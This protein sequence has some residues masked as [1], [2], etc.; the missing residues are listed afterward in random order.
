MAATRNEIDIV[1]DGTV[2][3]DPIADQSFI[4][5]LFKNRGLWESRDGMGTLL[6]FNGD[7]NA[8]YNSGASVDTGTFGLEEHLGSFYFN[9]KT[10]QIIS[11][12][13]GSGWDGLT[14]SGNTDNVKHYYIHIYD[15]TT[16]NR[17]T[18]ILYTHTSQENV[19]DQLTGFYQGYYESRGNVINFKDVVLATKTRFFFAEYLG[20][21][22]FGSKDAGV[23]VYNPALFIKTRTKLINNINNRN[24]LADSLTNHYSEGSMITPLAFKD[25][26]VDAYTYVQTSDINNIVD[27]DANDG[28]L[29]FAAGKSLYFSDVGVPNA[30]VGNNVF[31]FHELQTNITAIKSFNEL[32][33]VWSA[34]QMFVYQPSQG[35]LLSGGRAV[36]VNNEVGCLGP[37]AVLFRQNR[38]WWVD[39]NG[40]YSTGTG[41]STEEIS[42]PIKLFFTD[43]T[44]NPFIHY[45]TNAGFIGTNDNRPEFVLSA[46]NNLDDVHLAFDQKYEQLFVVFPK[47]NL[48]WVYKE[49]G[50]YI[51]SFSSIAEANSTVSAISSVDYP[52]IVCSNEK[53]FAVGGKLTNDVYYTPNSDG[54]G[55]SL[56]GKQFSWRLFELGRGGALDGSTNDFN[57]GKRGTGYYNTTTEGTG[58]DYTIYYDPIQ[59]WGNKLSADATQSTVYGEEDDLCVLPIWITPAGDTF[60]KITS[61]TIEF[62][63]DSTRFE[64][65]DW[66]GSPS[67]RDLVFVLPTER[68]IQYLGFS[69]GNAA[70]GPPPSGVSKPLTGTVRIQFNAALAASSWGWMNLNPLNKNAVIWIPFKKIRRDSGDLDTT[71]IITDLGANFTYTDG[72]G[73]SGNSTNITHRK[74]NPGWTHLRDDVEIANGVDWVYKS[75]QLGMEG[76]TQ[77]KARG[78]YSLVASRGVGDKIKNWSIGVWNSIAGSDYKDYVTQTLDVTDTPKNREALVTIFNKNDIRTRFKPLTD[79]LYRL[80][81]GSATYGSNVDPNEPGN[82]LVDT[83]EADTIATSDSVR[84]ESVNYTFFGF[85]LNKANKVRI[86]SIKIPFIPVAGRRRRGR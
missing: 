64:P 55:E 70:A 15:I 43:S 7:L 8:R 52:F 59:S 76:Q 19:E 61:F 6:E 62:Q 47:L 16:N 80:F 81:G 30:I 36:E 17:W 1:V 13:Y 74:W 31:T 83:E 18:E 60:N 5:N 56:I 82:Y 25:G 32:I 45:F 14:P 50:W 71:N 21:L 20:K 51:W 27:I 44:T 84:G 57:E 12:F 29:I 73:G 37:N 41:F 33:L 72:L 48:A 40:V 3:K 66:V 65:I 42:A 68:A 9:T 85:L 10:E 77:I 38:V 49:G 24:E 58:A 2:L 75:S 86:K 69:P 63:Y 79:L 11:V 78:S 67:L 34:D 35:F 23:W 4:Q 46:D 53:T 28:R 39:V 22:Y 54:S 26:L